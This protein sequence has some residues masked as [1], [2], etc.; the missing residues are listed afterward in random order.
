[1]GIHILIVEAENRFRKNL[2]THLQSEGFT[3]DKVTLQDDVETIVVKEKI[4][5]VLLGVDGLGREGLTLIQPIKAIRPKTEIISLNDHTQMDLSIE[6]M[7]LGAFDDFLV[8][9]DIQALV[10]CIRAA[11]T[12]KKRKAI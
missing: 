4:D 5:A 3:V 8:P 2:Y 11:V 12:H 1:M 10:T 7:E 9:L 6:A